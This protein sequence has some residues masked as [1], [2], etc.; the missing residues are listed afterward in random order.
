MSVLDATPAEREAIFDACWAKGGLPFLAGFGDLFE[1]KEANDFAADYVRRRIHAL[2]KDPDIAD[3]LS[4]ETIIGCKRL[5]VDT[6]YYV[7]F[8]RDNVTLVDL[9][10]SPIKHI[11]ATGIVTEAE[12]YDLDA[13][14]YATGFDA[15]TG[16]LNKIDITGRGG[17]TL[18]QKWSAGARSYLG[19]GFAGFPNLFTVNGPGSPSVLSNVLQSIEQHVD[20]IGD[21][22]A[23]MTGKGYREVAVEEEA[24]QAWSAHVNSLAAASVYPQCNSW[25]LGA[26]IPGK[27]RVFLAYI[28]F[29]DYVEKVEALTRDDYRGFLFT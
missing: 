9:K 10:K 27:P 6:D 25:Y 11:T 15:L 26:N 16:A 22:I 17:L 24:E 28:G 20:W 2:V 12:T 3:A 5:C 19:L 23:Y 14:I 7:T 18:R 8:N 29:P 13:I 4:P 1:S 21:C